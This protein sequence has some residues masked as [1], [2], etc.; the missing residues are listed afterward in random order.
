MATQ[1]KL[2]KING[3]HCTSCSILID[4]DLEDRKGVKSARTNYAKQMTEVEFND[5]EISTDQLIEVIK[6]AGYDASLI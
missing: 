4:G 5:E 2:L 6:K 1:K 3:M